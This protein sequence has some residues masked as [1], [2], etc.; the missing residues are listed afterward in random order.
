LYELP[1][2]KIDIARNHVDTNL[3]DKMVSQVENILRLEYSFA[4]AKTS[5]KKQMVQRQIETTDKQIDTL[6]YELYELTEE[7]IR[8]VEES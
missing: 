6:V 4:A 8:I 5:I 1:F 3:H 7:E 2:P